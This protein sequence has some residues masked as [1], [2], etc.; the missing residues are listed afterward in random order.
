MAVKEHED[1]HLKSVSSTN[2][3]AVAPW[4]VQQRGCSR[5]LVKIAY[6][7]KWPQY[8]FW[9]ALSFLKTP[10]TSSLVCRYSTDIVTLTHL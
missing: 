2:L 8:K 3:D 4:R 7:H 9:L 5:A 10:P 1:V 6:T